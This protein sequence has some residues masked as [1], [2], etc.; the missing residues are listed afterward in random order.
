MTI[1][2]PVFNGERFLAQ[3]LDSILSQT[4]QDF[5]VI[6][7][8]NASFDKTEA[9]CHE[10]AAKD[11][12]IRYYRNAVNL[13]V[14]ANF[15]RVFRLSSSDYFK[16]AAYDDIHAPDFLEKC[17][18]VLDSNPNVSLCHSRTG[19]IDCHGARVGEYGVPR[20]IDSDK[21]HERFEN[22]ICMDND[23]WVLMYGL[24]RSSTL[25]RTHLLGSYIGSDR[26]LLA[27]ISLFGQCYEIPELL[28]FRR[29]HS[30]SYTDRAN[31][32]YSEKLKWWTNVEVKEKAVFPYWR[33]CLEYFNS[34]SST[35]ISWAD[36]QRCYAKI[37]EWI[38]KQGW[39]LMGYDVGVNLIGKSSLRKRWS[40]L[41]EWLLRHAN[42][43]ESSSP[44]TTNGHLRRTQTGRE[45]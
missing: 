27:E 11:D 23:A 36:K 5:Q 34:V 7:S 39:I 45:D 29:E 10:Y 26:N 17:V 1:G 43:R 32:T 20:K 12:R 15:N 14:S 40:P 9:I 31:V 28:F 35:P 3:A 42:L 41:A 21:L 33:I 22:L 38:M 2:V 44:R 8:D 4:F 37:T 13:G 6:I 24:M 19:R 16:W 30:E 25:K 18:S